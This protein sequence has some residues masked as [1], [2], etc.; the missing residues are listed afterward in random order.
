MKDLDEGAD[1]SPRA[2]FEHSVQR[3]DL[4]AGN[5]LRLARRAALSGAGAHGG[6]GLG[7]RP[8]LAAAVVLALGL[9][10]WMPTRFGAAP[11]PAPAPA[12][13]ATAAASD[14]AL[15]SAES[16]DPDLYAWLAEAP[17]AADDAGAEHKL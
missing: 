10:W 6:H 3:L 1:A 7:W 13:I 12:A 11:A 14:D 9:A 15:I 4:P 17:V 5:R 16:D 8:A 2:L